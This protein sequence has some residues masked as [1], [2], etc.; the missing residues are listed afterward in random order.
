MVRD[1]RSDRYR[2]TRMFVLTLGYRRKAVR[3]LTWHSNTRIWAELHERAFQRLGGAPR[4]LILDN[5]GEGVLRPDVYDPT[6]NP[7]Y[8]DLLAH[9]GAAPCRVASG[10]RIE[11]ARWNEPSAMP[12]RRR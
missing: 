12:N 4:L 11:K 6:A 10:T 2:R 1:P 3:I 8:A 7:L 9:Y 5:L